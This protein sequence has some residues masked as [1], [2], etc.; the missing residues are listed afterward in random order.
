MKA[1]LAFSIGCLVKPEILILDEVFAVG[2]GAFRAKSAKKMDEILHGGATGILVSHSIRQ[3]RSMSRKVLWLDHGR[4]IAFGGDVQ[5]ICDAYER[6]LE[7][8]VLPKN[9]AEQIALAKQWR[10]KTNA[11][12]PH[13]TTGSDGGIA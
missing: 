12:N 7:T 4:Q 5:Q 3:I 9:D 1:R 8:G 11:A 10:E 6:F 2:D 13:E